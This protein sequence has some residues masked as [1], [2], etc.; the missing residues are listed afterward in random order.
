MQRK[1]SGKSRDSHADFASE[2]WRRHA[3]CAEIDPELFFPD[4]GD[5]ARD[6]KRIC[7]AC[8]VREECLNFAVAYRQRFGIWGGMTLRER[9]EYI[10]GTRLDA[11]Q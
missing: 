7:C 5:S 6:A 10:A 11:W 2:S 1:V 4:V 8:D 9:L 3:V